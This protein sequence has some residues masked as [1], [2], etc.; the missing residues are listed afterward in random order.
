ML[1]STN[2]QESITRL[3]PP[4]NHASLHFTL[5]PTHPLTPSKLIR[6]HLKPYLPKHGRR[7]FA[8]LV[9]SRIGYRSAPRVRLEHDADASLERIAR[10]LLD[11]GHDF[12]DRMVVVVIQDD[13]VGAV[14][15]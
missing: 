5:S 13:H 9:A 6:L 3:S 8:S 11:L 1:L 14:L 12:V 7:P 2:I 10:R 15:A 4:Y